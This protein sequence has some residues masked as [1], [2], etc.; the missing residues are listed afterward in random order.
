MT[1]KNILLIQYQQKIGDRLHIT[2]MKSPTFEELQRA[3]R[4]LKELYELYCHN[5][6]SPIIVEGKRDKEA[7]RRLGIKGEILPLNNGKSIY[8]FCEFMLDNY[9]SVILL[10]DWDYKGESIFKTLSFNLSG[11][12]EQYSSIRENMKILC[13]KD[14]KDIEAL[15]SLLHRLFGKEL[16]VQDYEREEQLKGNR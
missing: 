5:K 7:L 8:D 13:Q 16:T 6:S 9:N 10:T 15:P 14:I 11:L 1:L 2:F 4:I 12:W 3:E